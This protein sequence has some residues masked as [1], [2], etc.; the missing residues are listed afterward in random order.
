MCFIL[1]SSTEPTGPRGK[2]WALSQPLLAPFYFFHPSLEKIPSA[3]C[4]EVY[5][6]PCSGLCLRPQPQGLR[7]GILFRAFEAQ[8]WNH[9]LTAQLYLMERR[10]WETPWGLLSHGSL[11]LLLFHHVLRQLWISGSGPLILLTWVPPVVSRELT[12]QDNRGTLIII[13]KHVH[14]QKEYKHHHKLTL[15]NREKWLWAL[16]R[17]HIWDDFSAP[18]QAD[19]WSN[20]EGPQAEGLAFASISDSQMST[21]GKL[22]S[23]EHIPSSGN[24]SS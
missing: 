4:S 12:G 10:P 11:W 18:P 14:S 22:S 17:Y 16:K 7:S 3:L 21:R 6:L 2:C 1:N 19:C 9:M 20:L 24:F 23:S 5:S 13:F 15:P 8:C